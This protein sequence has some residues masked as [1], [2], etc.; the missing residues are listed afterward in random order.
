MNRA[1]IRSILAALVLALLSGCAG[2]YFDDAGTP[3][4]PPPRFALADLPFDEYWTGL[5]FNGNKIGFTHLAVDTAA[6][7]DTYVVRSEA[8]M[9]FRF[10]AV[11]KQV[12]LKSEDWIGADLALKRF[13]YAYHI[14]G[15][16]LLL[17]GKRSGD[18]LEVRIESRGHVREQRFDLSGPLYPSSIIALYPV[19][20]GLEVGRDYRFRV[21]DGETQ[22]IAEVT[23]QVRAYET[24]DLFDGTAFKVH[25]RLRGHSADTW[26]DLE[27]RPVLEISGGGIFIAGLESEATARRYLALAALNKDEVLLDFAR[28]PS[29][30]PIDAPRS[31][32][33]LS[34][35]LQG[36]D[37]LAL[38]SDGMQRCRREGGEMLCEI[39]S[40]PG[41]GFSAE[42]E[43]FD[44][45][46]YLASTLPVASDHPEIRRLSRQL[47][48]GHTDPHEQMAALVAWIQDNVDQQAVDVFSAIDVL[49]TRKAECQGNTFLYAAFARAR[50]IPTR[51][52]NGIVYSEELGGFL[53]HTWAES[54]VEKRWQ[55]VDPTFGQVRA[56]A[57]HIKLAEGE[58]LAD[59]D[60]L[61]AVMG[62]LKA[63][64]IALEHA[65]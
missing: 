55:A 33:A 3:P 17:T 27:G 16:E 37:T 9:R 58:S 5:V 48:E 19:V 14:D 54:H 46:R 12:T 47:T 32:T 22:T 21:F 44:R 53:Y 64:V 51:V 24:S 65:E 20:N 62:R 23:Q 57:T 61:L 2:L 43:P 10:L 18:A 63:R 30:R 7:P 60:P 29:S 41:H 13:N 15:S 35:A 38:P 28:V 42:A 39:R 8:V 56:D 52:V 11:D 49:E 31:V 40:A 6:Q 25:S 4:Q 1:A 45:Q 50:G 34:V 59:L 26:L 36:L